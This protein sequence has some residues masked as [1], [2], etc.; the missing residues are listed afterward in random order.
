MLKVRAGVT[1]EGNDYYCCL[2]QEGLG[3]KC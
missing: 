1:R 3:F 2:I